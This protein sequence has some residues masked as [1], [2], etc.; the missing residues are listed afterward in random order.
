MD[1][2][3]VNE[4]MER[5]GLDAIT[6]L[7]RRAQSEKTRA[8]NEKTRADNEKTR[9][10][11]EKTRADNEKTR[12][13]NFQADLDNARCEIAG[14]LLIIERKRWSMRLTSCSTQHNAALYGAL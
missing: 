4:L 2:L 14:C 1:K 7:G 13:D 9:A 11:N 8:D 6:E 10:D 5:G 3:S 12:A